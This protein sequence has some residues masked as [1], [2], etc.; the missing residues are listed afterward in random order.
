MSAAACSIL[1]RL[2]PLPP[3]LRIAH[4]AALLRREPEDSPRAAVFRHLLVAQPA[5]GDGRAG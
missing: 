1:A 2:R 5:S 4:L 3:R